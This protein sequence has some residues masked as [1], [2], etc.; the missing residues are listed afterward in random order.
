MA[1]MLIF[2]HLGFPWVSVDFKVD[3]FYAHNNHYCFVSVPMA[4]TMTFLHERLQHGMQCF[5][6][7]VD[8]D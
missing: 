6:V 4:N 8:F 3:L 2:L 5:R 7:P 1:N